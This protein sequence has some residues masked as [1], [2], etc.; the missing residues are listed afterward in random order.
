MPAGSEALLGAMKSLLNAVLGR[1]RPPAIAQRAVRLTA[2][3]RPAL[4]YAVGD[5]HGCLDA[6]LQLEAG[7]VADARAEEG[8][9]WLV[10][11]GDY[12]DRGPKAAQVIDHLLAP[13]PVG[14]RRICLRGNHEAVMLA[15]LEDAVALDDW[16]ALGGD[17]TLASYGVGAAQLDKLRRQAGSAAS[18]L[19]IVKAHIPE[20]HIRFVSE[21]ASALSVPGYVFVHAGLR[22]GVGLEDQDAE[23]MMWIRE[24]FLDAAHDFGAVV[25]HG[26]T[27]ALEPELLAHRIGIDT[28]CFMS[29]RLT[30]LRL[31]AAGAVTFLQT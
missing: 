24:A 16:M 22:P 6:L 5:I 19:Q 31:D 9:K 17:A 30:A 27:I 10:Y 21:L 13:P 2:E 29:G 12:I 18:R 20:E 11:L 14:F 1:N 4:L 8:E 15:A 23:D 7:I 25:V 3:Q 26:H 28:G